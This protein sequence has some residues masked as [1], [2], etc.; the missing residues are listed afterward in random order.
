MLTPLV[1][2]LS[3][4]IATGFVFE[5]S[6]IGEGWLEFWRGSIVNQPDNHVLS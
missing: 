3:A 6:F 1:L 2:L 4:P 5:G